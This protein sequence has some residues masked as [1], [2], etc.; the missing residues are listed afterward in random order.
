MVTIDGYT[1]GDATATTAD[2]ATENTLAQGTNAV[3]KI[4]STG[5][6]SHRATVSP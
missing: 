4:R 2:D 1:Q 6:T 5:R 3:L